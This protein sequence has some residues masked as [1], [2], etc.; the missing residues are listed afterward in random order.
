MTIRPGARMAL[1]LGAVGIV[2]AVAETIALGSNE[3]TLW[4]I[5]KV[6]WQATFSTPLVPLIA[7]ILMGH[8]FFPKGKCV[9][10]GGRPWATDAD[11]RAAFVGKL[12]RFANLMRVERKPGDNPD[13]QDLMRRAGFPVED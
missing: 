11:G 8:F 4:T 13:T 6:V 2:L 3:S 1:I 12:L 10:C 5:S 7:G 9:L